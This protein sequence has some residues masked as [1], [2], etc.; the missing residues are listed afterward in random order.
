[1]KTLLQINTNVGWNSTGRIAEDI[2]KLAIEHGWL[3]TIA[4][5]RNMNG[6]PASTSQLVRVGSNKDIILHGIAT[7][8]FD[9]HGLHSRK[10]TINLIKRI[11]EINPDIIHLQN[12]HGY[13]LNYQEL[14]AYFARSGKPLVWTLHDCW[15]FTG[16]CAYFDIAN[17]SKWING[18]SHCPL[19]T[20][21]PAS[22]A[23]DNSFANYLAKKEAFTSVD[24]LYIV[25][26]SQWL[27]DIVDQ[28]FLG[29]YPSFVVH[30]GVDIPTNPG[31]R[32]RRERLVLGAASKWDR[33]KGLDSFIKLRKALPPE[34]RIVLIG[35]SSKQIRS[36][37]HG[38]EGLPRIND[39]SA[40]YDWYRRAAVFVNPSLSENLSTTNLESQACGT[41][42]VAFNIGGTRETIGQNTGMVVEPGDID[43]MSEAILKI[44][45]SPKV[46]SADA[47]R[48]FIQANFNKAKNYSTYIDIYESILTSR[49]IN[50]HALQTPSSV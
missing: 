16:H 46:F 27:K 21:Y 2:G 15:P 7:R 30:N 19:K 22:F 41:P 20:T 36:L 28:S 8:L 45:A 31:G 34:F 37:P 10:A 6:T 11:D 47:C 17:C 24:N 38:I 26:V 25:T 42:V 23:C 39:R 3:S 12:I 50:I 18:C 44:T 32:V 48:Q 9:R 40:F 49:N 43:A 1:M 14:F 29:K 4:Y 13:Y 35:L 5:G 33:R